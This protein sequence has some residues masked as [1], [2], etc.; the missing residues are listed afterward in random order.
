MG[1]TKGKRISMIGVP[2]NLGADRLGV[3]LGPVA[4]RHAGVKAR[5]EKLGYQLEDKGDLQ[6]T[7]PENPESV[8]TNLK[9]LSEI[10]RVNT[11]LCDAVSEALGQGSMPLV[12]GGDHSIAIGTLA[13]LMQHQKNLG[14]I[15]FDAHG[16]INTAETSPSGNIHGMPVAVAMGL[17]HPQLTAI[18]GSDNKL[19]PKNFVLIGSRDLDAGERKLLKEL[20]VTVFSMHEVDLMG[21]AK[22]TEEAIRIASEG[23]DGVHVSFD[24]DAMDPFHA[25]GTGTRVPGGLTYRECHLSLEL[26]AKSGVVTSVEF[27]EVNPL[28]DYKNETAE[29]AVALMGSLLGEWLI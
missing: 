28:L 3:D 19:N 8:G 12:L 16:D 25:T 4:I 10:T 1:H 22:V 5:L 13:G 18:G 14:V 9:Y 21:I 29:T 24:M 20:G 15:W 7:R 23:A 6:V 11:A 27:V 26:I 17:G 2:L